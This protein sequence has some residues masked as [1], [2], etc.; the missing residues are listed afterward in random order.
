MK[1]RL[2]KPL[3]SVDGSKKL[4]TTEKVGEGED[5]TSIEIL[6]FAGLETL[7]GADIE[8]CVREAQNFKG[9]VVRVLATD[10]DLHIQ[11]AAKATGVAVND[12]RRLGAKDFVEVA[13]IVQGFLTGL[14]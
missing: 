12:L 10:L 7:T 5:A 3:M 4:S 14:V 9:E 13:T 1:V 11:V 6:D 8:Q 2:V